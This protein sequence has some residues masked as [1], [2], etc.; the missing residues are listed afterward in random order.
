MTV[1]KVIDTSVWLLYLGGQS[2]EAEE[3]I[4]ASD[5]LIISSITLYE[6][7]RKLLKLKVL[8]ERVKQE[9]SFIKERALVEDVDETLGEDAATLGHEHSLGMADAII[10]ATARKYNAQLITG[11]NDF[12]GLPMVTII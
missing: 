10:Y 4:D 8:P 1:F 12:R 11:D 2:K 6:V 9:V 5:Q 3:V 7:K